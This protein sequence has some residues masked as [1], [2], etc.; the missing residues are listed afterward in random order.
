MAEHDE[1]L[2]EEELSEARAWGM[3][4]VRYRQAKADMAEAERR[5]GAEAHYEDAAMRREAEINRR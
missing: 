4:E 2:T 5:Y 1:P 3:D